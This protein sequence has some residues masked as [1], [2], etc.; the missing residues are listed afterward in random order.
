MPRGGAGPVVACRPVPGCAGHT[1]SLHP[2]QALPG[3]TEFSVRPR[4]HV[5]EFNEKVIYSSIN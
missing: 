2:Y 5:R 1:P 3:D 4:I